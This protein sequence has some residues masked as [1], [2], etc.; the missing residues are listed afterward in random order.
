[1][2]RYVLQRCR[3]LVAMARYGL[4]QRS[5][6]DRRDGVLRLAALAASSSA[7]ACYWSRL[8]QLEIV[9]DKAPRL[10]ERVRRSLRRA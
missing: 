1:M 5:G 2:A 10:R 7:M 4:L 3:E 9:E 8:R 6:G